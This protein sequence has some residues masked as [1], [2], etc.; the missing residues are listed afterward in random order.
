MFFGKNGR[1]NENTIDKQLKKMD[2]SQDP[3]H[4]ISSFL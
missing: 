3:R 4:N 2:L 1:L